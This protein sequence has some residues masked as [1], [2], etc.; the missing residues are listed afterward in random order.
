MIRRCPHC[1][2]RRTDVMLNFVGYFV[3][4][5][6]FNVLYTALMHWLGR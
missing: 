1:N 6:V 3:A 5:G 4:G 2:Q